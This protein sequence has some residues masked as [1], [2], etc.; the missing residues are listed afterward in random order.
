MS[1]KTIFL[2]LLTASFLLSC[3][4]NEVEEKKVKVGKTMLCEKP[5]GSKKE[6]DSLSLSAK[7]LEKASAEKDTA[8]KPKKDMGGLVDIQTIEPSILVD[9]KYASTDNFM[10][11][12]LYFDID[13][14]YLQ[15]DVA[16]RLA[17]V[18]HYLQEL[19]PDLTLLVY[20]GVRPLSVQWAMWRALDTIPVKERVKFVSNPASGSI[21]NY[22]AAIDLTIAK[23]DGTP[24]DM[25]AGY[26][27]IRKIAYPSWE[28]HFLQTGELTKQQVENRKLLRKVMQS[29]G[30]SNI[31]TEW[32]HFNACSRVQ[33][34]ARYKVLE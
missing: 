13:K 14:L 3:S 26:D 28:S 21:H 33:A 19:R 10:K 22:G 24:L 4:Q 9:L 31:K 8:V 30:F 20:D 7:P 17:K 23:K 34:K 2:W 11:R 5:G 27:D 15:K 12:R 16:E 6:N 29:Q 25:G 1:L 32:W 18:Q